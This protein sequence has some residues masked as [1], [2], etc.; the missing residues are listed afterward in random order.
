M[1]TRRHTCARSEQAIGELLAVIGEDV[2]N[3]DGASLMQRLQEFA[4]ISIERLGQE[5]LLICVQPETELDDFG[6]PA[7][8]PVAG[9]EYARARQRR[10]AGRAPDDRRRLQR[11]KTLDDADARAR[12]T[13]PTLCSSERRQGPSRT[14]PLG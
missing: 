10:R 9:Q 12:Q 3:F 11:G 1:L 6:R 13:G 14:Q 8:A 4:R 5:P 7:S 2:F